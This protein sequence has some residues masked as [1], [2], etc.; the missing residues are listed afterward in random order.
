MN[1]PDPLAI[2]QDPVFFREAVSFTAADTSFAPRLVE[3]DY[4]CTLLLAHLGALDPLVFKGGTCLAKVYAG[5][6]RLSE[7]LD[8]AASLPVDAPRQVRRNFAEPLRR[9]VA[10]LPPPF[11]NPS[12]MTGHNNSLQYNG[13]AV[14]TSLLDGREESIHIELSLREPLLIPPQ[15]QAVRTVLLDPLTGRNM[16][17][18]VTVNCIAEQ[19]AFAEKIRAALS[20]RDVAIRDFFDL[21]HAVRNLSLVPTDAALI[22]LVKQKLSIPGN[23]PVNVSAVR[24][25]LLRGQLEGRLRPVLRTSDFAA[26][27]LNRAIALITT[28]AA[29]LQQ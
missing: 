1:T 4:F 24:L 14:Y 23:E 22:A 13:A 11:R 5:F 27:D 18:G 9:A 19:E 21:D 2:H 3:K 29:A 17:E 6:Y 10:A 8:F 15:S 26:F 16:V 25:A 20:R 28:I 12:P 7:D